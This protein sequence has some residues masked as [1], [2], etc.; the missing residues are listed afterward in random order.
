MKGLLLKDFYM[1]WKY[2]RPFFFILLMFLVL[3]N[4]DTGNLFF[5]MYPAILMGMIPMTLYSYDER[6]RW[7]TYSQTMP[8]SRQSY[9]TEKYL[10]G[11]L[12][13]VFY[14]AI[15]TIVSLI[16]TKI[17]GREV[18]W[19]ALLAE[20]GVIL[21]LGLFSQIVTMPLLMKL[22]AEKGRM[23]YL[24]VIG[25]MCG[26]IAYA[27]TFYELDAGRFADKNPGVGSGLLL[28]FVLYFLSWLLSVRLYKKREL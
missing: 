6:E 16:L 22:G 17:A 20:I 26:V 9:V 4:L 10:F 5:I 3:G 14:A 24:L 11:F 27:V 15:L 21:M 23:V 1:A 8:V 28:I 12:A 25:V 19:S 2:C 18:C 13:V 7:C